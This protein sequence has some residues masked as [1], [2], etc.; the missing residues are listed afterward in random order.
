M[1]HGVDGRANHPW[2]SALPWT[3][4]KKKKQKKIWYGIVSSER[5][6]V[7]TQISGQIDTTS[8]PKDYRNASLWKPRSREEVKSICHS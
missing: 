3:K 7:S 5:G 4:K 2:V 1:R 8:F 6:R